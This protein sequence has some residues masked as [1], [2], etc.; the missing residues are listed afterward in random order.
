MRPWE[1]EKG[2]ARKAEKTEDR[3]VKSLGEGNLE[4]LKPMQKGGDGRK[5]Q[6]LPPSEPDSGQKKP[7]WVV[8]T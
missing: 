5:D 7:F 3:N 6:T 2:K 8:L 4:S 1:G